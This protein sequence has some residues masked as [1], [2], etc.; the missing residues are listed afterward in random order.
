MYSNAQYMLIFIPQYKS[1]E[2]KT[3]ISESEIDTGIIDSNGDHIPV[4]GTDEKELTLHIQR[5]LKLQIEFAN[6][7]T[8]LGY[9]GGPNAIERILQSRRGRQRTRLEQYI[10]KT[11][12]TFT[13]FEERE[14]GHMPRR[15]SVLKKLLK[16]GKEREQVFLYSSDL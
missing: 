2:S 3:K 10:V 9:L 4:S 13:S 11:V 8:L 15:A 5:C 6:Q 12:F 16:A 1:S 7:L 14:R